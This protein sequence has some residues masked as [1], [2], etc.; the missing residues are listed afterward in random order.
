MIQKTGG[1]LGALAVAGI[2]GAIFFF[3]CVYPFLEDRTQEFDCASSGFSD[4]CDDPGTI[5]GFMALMC[6]RDSVRG[7]ATEI[8]TVGGEPGV[9]EPSS[10][11]IL[12]WCGATKFAWEYEEGEEIDYLD[13]RLARDSKTKVATRVFRDYSSGF[14][15]V[16]EARRQLLAAR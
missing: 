6:G 3:Q 12:I 13:E 15:G 11:E 2:V 10:F 1:F 8:K 16:S 5:L 14:I 7:R 9:R 4:F